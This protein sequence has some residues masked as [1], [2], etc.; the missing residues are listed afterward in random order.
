MDPTLKIQWTFL[1]NILG[2]SMKT[3]D[4]HSLQLWNSITSYIPKRNVPQ[5]VYSKFGHRKIAVILSTT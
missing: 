4:I 3:E 1:E 2:E 5:N